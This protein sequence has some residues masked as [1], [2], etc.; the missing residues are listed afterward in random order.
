MS[1]FAWLRR[2]GRPSS[3]PES[4]SSAGRHSASR[5]PASSSD[6]LDS[7]AARAAPG[8]RAFPASAFPGAATAGRLLRRSAAVLL[9][10]VVSAPAVL[11]QTLPT[12]TIE[13]PVPVITESQ[14]QTLRVRVS[15]TQTTDLDVL[16][17]VSWLIGP[18]LA[19]GQAGVRTVT[20]PANF[21]TTSFDI[22][23]VDDNVDS[24]DGVI[25]VTVQANPAYQ[26]GSASFSDVVVTDNDL[27]PVNLSVSDGGAASEGGGALTITATTPP[28]ATVSSHVLSIPIQV[29]MAGTTAQAADYT[30]AGTIDIP[31]NAH[32]GTTTFTVTDDSLVEQAE[33]VVVELGTPL[34]LPTQ[35]RPGA[36]DAV[37]ITI[38]DNDPG[39]SFDAATF[40]AEEG[41]PVRVTLNLN[42]P[43]T[44]ATPVALA[45]AA[46]AT[47]PAENSDYTEVTPVSILANALTHSFDIQTV[48]DADTDDDTFTI[49]ISAVQGAPVVGSPSVATVTIK[50]ID[51]SLTLLPLGAPRIHLDALPS[52]GVTGSGRDWTLVE[53][54]DIRLRFSNLTEDLHSEDLVVDYAVVGANAHVPAGHGG[55]RSV[56]I[57]ANTR[58][59]EVTLPTEAATLDETDVSL[60]VM[61]LAAGS[62]T[63]TTAGTYTTNFRPLNFTVTDG[64]DGGTGSITPT[65]TVETWYANFS[66]DPVNEPDKG[67]PRIE[68]DELQFDVRSVPAASV[69]FTVWLKVEETVGTGYGDCVAAGQ[70]RVRTV[71]F[72]PG[73]SRRTLRVPT[74]D[75]DVDEYDCEV[76]VSLASNASGTVPTGDVQVLTGGR[77]GYEIDVDDGAVATRKVRDNEAGPKGSSS[78]DGIGPV[79]PGAGPAVTISADATEVDEGGDVTFTVTAD[80]APAQDLAVNLSA[81]WEMGA[82]DDRTGGGDFWTVTVRAGAASATWTYT[83][84]SDDD[85]LADG[86]VVGRI[87]AGDGY[88]PGEPSSVTLTLLDDDEPTTDGVVQHNVPDSVVVDPVTPAVDPALVAQVRDYAAET[89]KHPDH[90]DRWMRVLAAFGDDNGYTAMTAAE[91]QTHAD[92]GWQRWV[93]VVAALNALEA[94]GSQQDQQDTDQQGTDQQVVTPEPPAVCVSPELLSDVEGYAGETH[95]G[96]AHVERWLRVLH[97]LKGMANDSTIMLSAEAQ[98]HADKGWQRWVPVVTAI[99]CLEAGAGGN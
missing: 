64:P 45:Y 90:V 81:D 28:D 74:V 35:Y 16:V 44:T 71:R 42:L 68:G 7:S 47:D 34:P 53:G 57:P 77:G 60:S 4:L 98:T 50:E 70:E 38:A 52:P 6:S 63:E 59:V 97:T 65:V 40:T 19:S 37:T 25:R 92:K 32:S 96:A 36:N 49:T 2:R 39:V 43:Q 11:A 5:R 10:L 69:P 20:I 83:T 91:A 54:T 80:P 85:D 66:N 94:V 21:P 58:S 3:P 9:L 29:R 75:D 61:L 82:G 88:E 72:A 31:A 12:V 79:T 56:T 76:R 62:S 99:E 89:W 41:R 33:T 30:L 8:P 13:P 48:A 22:Q 27:T 78:D 87:E 1:A 17:D 51:T 24:P 23:T 73:A 84:T 95:E 14:A 93:P 15:P 26:L 46:G 67:D 55:T 18:P 86:T